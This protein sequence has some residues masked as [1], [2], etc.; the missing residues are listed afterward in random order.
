[1]LTILSS[2]REMLADHFSKYSY[3]LA[4][5]LSYLYGNQKL[6]FIMNASSMSPQRIY[7]DDVRGHQMEAPPPSSRIGDVE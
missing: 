7:T 6:Y 1:M 3:S 5:A 2:F 4:L